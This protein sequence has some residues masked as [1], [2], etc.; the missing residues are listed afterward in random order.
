MNPYLE[1]PLRWQSVHALL[2]TFL[3]GTLNRSLPEGYVAQMEERIYVLGVQPTPTE[4]HILRLAANTITERFL[5]I[6]SRAEIAHVI[7]TIEVL[8][9]ANKS[10]QVGRREY[11]EKQ[12]IAL[13]SDSN[14]LEI[15]LLREGQ[16]LLAAPEEALRAECSTWDYLVCLHRARTTDF[17]YW[18]I[19]LPQPLPSVRVPLA[20]ADPDMIL[21]LQEILN[22]AY[23]F[24]ALGR[25]LH[26]EAQPEPPLPPKYTA[27]AESLLKD[28]GYRN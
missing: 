8:S 6:V 25:S 1:N 3:Y 15:D 19:A 7:T 20:Q 9:P 11:R 18:P 24:G 13:K 12:E 10:T 27:W 17:E 5:T 21:D 28:K 2:I 22:Q 16:Y 4:P 26:Y 23:D 14:L